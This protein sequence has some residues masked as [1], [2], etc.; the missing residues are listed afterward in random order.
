MERNRQAEH[1]RYRDEARARLASEP[2]DDGYHSNRR[3]RWRDRV[4]R[5]A[6]CL[7]ELGPEDPTLER[8]LRLA[9]RA[10]MP[11]A[12]PGWWRAHP[13]ARLNAAARR[14][15]RW[16]DKRRRQYARRGRAGTALGRL[17]LRA[18]GAAAIYARHADIAAL[19]LC[20]RFLDLLDEALAGA[21]GSRRRPEGTAGPCR[22][23]SPPLRRTKNGG[24]EPPRRRGSQ[25]RERRNDV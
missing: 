11:L 8:I 4:S 13:K 24:C 5:V 21:G 14:Q 23:G 2:P 25:P 3:R 7:D 17:G 10:L 1:T 15:V 9:F 19:D 20:V 12:D 6:R 18:C 22:G 16:I